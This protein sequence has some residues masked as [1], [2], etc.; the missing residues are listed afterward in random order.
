[1]DIKL[2]IR[3]EMDIRINIKNHKRMNIKSKPAG[4]PKIKVGDYVC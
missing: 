4:L 1:M 3:I 2:D